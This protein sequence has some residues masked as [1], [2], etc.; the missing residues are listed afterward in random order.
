M[1]EVVAKG[2][3]G[4]SLITRFARTRTRMVHIGVSLRNRSIPSK[5]S[6]CPSPTLRAVV[7]LNL[8]AVF[9]LAEPERSA[10]L[11]EARMAALLLLGAGH[12][13]TAALA[14]AIIEPAALIAACRT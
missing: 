14:D 6:H 3:K 9:D 7:V 2:S 12:S 1:N 5:P 10:R 4:F 13:L 11:R 8:L